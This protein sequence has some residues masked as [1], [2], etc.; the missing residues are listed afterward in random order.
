[1]IVVFMKLKII[2]NSSLHIEH[3]IG[4]NEMEINK[5]EPRY[6]NNIANWK[7]DTQ[8]QCYLETMH[9]KIMKVM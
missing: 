7:P 4:P 2:S 8:D 9:I 5:I 1:M 3:E 6:I